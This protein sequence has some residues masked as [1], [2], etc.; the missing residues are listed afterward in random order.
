[1]ITQKIGGMEVQMQAV[2][3]EVADLHPDLR[4]AIERF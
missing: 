3:D 2:R 4:E 1:M